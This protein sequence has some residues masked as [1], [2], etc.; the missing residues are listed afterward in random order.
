MPMKKP[1]HLDP[2]FTMEFREF[3]EGCGGCLVTR[4]ECRAFAVFREG[5]EGRR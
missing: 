4:R 2:A 3:R 1:D 5:L